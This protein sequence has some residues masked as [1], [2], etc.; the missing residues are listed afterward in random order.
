MFSRLCFVPV[1][2]LASTCG[3]AVA[4][5]RPFTGGYAG[6]EAGVLEHHFGLVVKENGATVVDRYQRS[7]G[8]GGGAFIGHDWAVSENLRIGV[9]A[10]VTG[11]GETNVARLPDGTDFSLEPRWGYRLTARAGILANRNLLVYATGGLGGHRY[12]VTS[13]SARLQNPPI[14]GDSFVIGGGLEVV[15]SRNIGLRLDFK[16]LDNQT[17]QFFVGIPV[18]F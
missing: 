1:L 11:G 10:T 7:W 8:A 4:Q 17:N 16:H 9:E 6:P 14:S 15:V 13:N 12:E 18:R 2:I 3:A 5:E